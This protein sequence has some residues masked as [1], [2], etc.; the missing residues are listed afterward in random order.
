VGD[1]PPK[2]EVGD[3]LCIRPP[4]ISR[5]SVIGCVRKYELSKKSVIFFRNRGFS[6]RKGPYMPYIILQTIMTDKNK[7]YG[8]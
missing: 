6:S 5:S 8:R 3:S 7:K 2:F 4:N 1:G